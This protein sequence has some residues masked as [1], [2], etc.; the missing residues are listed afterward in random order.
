MIQSFKMLYSVYRVRNVHLQSFV[1]V[2]HTVRQYFW[3]NS[4]NQPLSLSQGLLHLP[5]WAVG[6]IISFDLTIVEVLADH[7]TSCRILLVNSYKFFQ[8][9]QHTVSMNASDCR[10]NRQ[11]FRDLIRSRQLRIVKEMWCEF[12]VESLVIGL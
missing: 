8:F 12:I 2:Y 10:Q 3:C 6:P 7:S 9:Q 4:F 11:V 1:N 5:D